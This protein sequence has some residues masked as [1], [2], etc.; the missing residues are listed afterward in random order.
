MEPKADHP[1]ILISC[2]YKSSVKG[3]NIILKHAFAYQL[4]GRLIV[5]DGQETMVFE[6]GDFRFN[7][8]NKL[9]KF[10]K[11][12]EG[13]IPFRSL[14]LQLDEEVLREFAAEHH[15]SSVS[16]PQTTPSFQLARHPL[17]QTFMDSLQQSLKY[18]ATDNRELVKLKLKEALVVLLQVQPALKDILFDFD[19]P[20]KI[21]LQVFMEQNFR[22]NLSI[23]RLA[24]LT[25]RSISGFKRDFFLSYG[26]TPAKWLQQ[27]RL[28][29][30]HYLLTE[31][32]MRTTDVYL[33]VGFENLSHF[34]YAFKKHYGFTPVQAMNGR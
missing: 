30:A 6:P 16:K 14:S 2:Y 31:K 27:K 12:P 23:A 3:E 7:V 28:E 20:G 29:E 21:N 33:E 25:G 24:Y 5:Q 32:Q 13:D 17:L 15:L 8:R 10:C 9:A 11:Q 1:G 22:Y 19:P 18:F 26:V 34:S 4:S